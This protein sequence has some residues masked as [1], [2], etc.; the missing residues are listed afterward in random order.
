MLRYATGG[1]LRAWVEGLGADWNGIG[2]RIQK[3]DVR[4]LTSAIGRQANSLRQKSRQFL[5][6]KQPRVILF[7]LAGLDRRAARG[8]WIGHGAGIQKVSDG[9]RFFY[10]DSL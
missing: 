7:M 8:G 3:D 9:E 4:A 5:G 1:E 2:V 6:K 10:L